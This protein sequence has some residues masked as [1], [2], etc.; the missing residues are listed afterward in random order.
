[1]SISSDEKNSFLKEFSDKMVQGRKLLQNANHQWANR[2]FVDLY[3]QIEKTE[4]LLPQERRQLTM[5][6]TNS[7]WMYLNLLSSN[8]EK[9]DSIK[10]IDAYNRFFSFLSQLDDF[11]LMNNF[12]TM[13]LKDFV[14]R[15][16]ISIE[17]ITKFINSF[18]V[19]IKKREDYLKLVELQVLLMYL[20]KS[21]Y[22]SDL[23]EF[24]FKF[25]GETLYKLE[26][27]KK[28][29]F[30]FVLMENIN[31]KYQISEKENESTGFGQE[32][33]KIL[34]NRLPNF[35]KEDFINMRKIVINERN[36]KTILV[37]L[38]E[39][40]LYL[41]NIGESSWII[42]ILRY[43]YTKINEYQSFKDALNYTKK[44]IDFSIYR[45]KFQLVFEIYDFLE[46]ILMYKSDL[47]YDTSL[48]ELWVE[49][50]KKLF[51]VKEKKYLLLSLEKL[52][53]NL[54]TPQTPTQIF[55]YFYT[56]NYI[57][58]F[59]SKFFSLDASDFWKMLFFR[60]LY[61]E[62]DFNLAQKI[63]PYLDDNLRSLLNDFSGLYSSAESIRNAIYSYKDDTIDIIKANKE[64][65]LNQAII[66]INSEGEINYRIIS[67]DFVMNEGIIK[68]E[69]WND[70]YLIELYH[71]IFSE[72]RKKQFNFNLNEF[73][74]II[75]I[76]LPK[77]LRNLFSKIKS[78]SP[79][80]IPQIYLILDHMTIPFELIYYG[81]TFFMLKCS[82]SYKIGEPPLGGIAFDQIRPDDTVSKA[83]NKKFKVLLI[84]A[85]NAKGPLRWNEE[86][87]N[88]TLIFPFPDAYDELLHIS[89]FFNKI[90]NVEQ[91][92]IL[93]DLNA[94]KEKIISQIS[95][96]NYHL[97]HVVGNVFYSESSPEKSYLLT[98][99]NNVITFAE[100]KSA[101]EKNRSLQPLLFFN[102][103]FYTLDG[104]KLKNPLRK[105]GELFKPF[106]FNIITG[107]I[108]RSLPLFNEDTRSIIANFY[109][110]LFNNNTQGI[111]LIAARKECKNS[112]ATASFI[113]FGKPWKRL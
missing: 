34:A 54:K 3:F 53:N 78:N 99:D 27:S 16:E 33:N 110:N 17:G 40:I 102:V 24:S 69:F 109:V 83:L 19:I 46:D 101:V 63:L 66:R 49:A 105:F 56:Y 29:L 81:D 73:G 31:F 55:H 11:D 12:W 76:F 85:T 51:D 14:K 60:A 44:F 113:Q 103:Q 20:R 64:Y 38:E 9:I 65:A 84:E 13:L 15:K 71:D 7:W 26:P 95:S 37:D 104:K 39:L 106:D 22:P 79:N 59:K 4:W 28:A 48:I 72:E 80:F 86:Y 6:I 92:A 42:I 100:I 5:I 18:C 10:F 61:E 112:L 107:I 23:L 35:L 25:L 88:K 52:Y 108:V 97:I 43:V 2:L 94:T 77:L 50:C 30:L 41:N 67:K 98:N 74:K 82:T 75:Y 91:L 62:K 96:G 32:I 58:Q 87:K 47:G 1:M 90:N 111:S 8:K 21:I 57:W 36:F 70:S 45:N 89:N 93:S 68:D